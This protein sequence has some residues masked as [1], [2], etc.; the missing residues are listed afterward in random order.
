MIDEDNGVWY[1][2]DEIVRLRA[3]LTVEIYS[4][5][6]ALLSKQREYYWRVRHDNGN[7]TADG[8]QG[9]ARKVNLMKMVG[10]MWPDLRVVEL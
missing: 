5:R 1:E 4:R 3:Q 6:R 8:S 10:Y 9:Y 2:D 7:I